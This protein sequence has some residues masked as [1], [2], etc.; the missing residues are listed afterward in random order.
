MTTYPTLKDINGNLIVCVP[1][2]R[3]SR[4][5]EY[6]V[7]KRVTK[8]QCHCC[9][10]PISDKSL[11][12]AMMVHMTV[13]QEIMP[14]DAVLAELVIAHARLVEIRHAAPPIAAMN[15]AI[16]QAKGMS[17]LPMPGE[18]ALTFAAGVRAGGVVFAAAGIGTY[19]FTTADTLPLLAV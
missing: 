2:K 13:N 4:A 14:A 15:A 10:K 12:T 18:T 6:A 3:P 8:H 16:S 5:Q 11:K 7:I 9:G 19:F 1:A 17:S